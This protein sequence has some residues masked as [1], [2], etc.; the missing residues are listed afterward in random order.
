M[1]STKQMI[2]FYADVI[3]RLT[4]ASTVN[5][6]CCND[7][8][9]ESYSTT[10]DLSK[11]LLPE[12]DPLEKNTNFPSLKNRNKS[13]V[14]H[15]SLHL[16]S[17]FK[18]QKEG[19]FLIHFNLYDTE[20]PFSES[21]YEQPNNNERRAQEDN[22]E[23]KSYSM[24]LGLSFTQQLPTWLSNDTLEA[25]SLSKHQFYPLL[26][27]I[28]KL[29]YI[30]INHLRQTTKLLQ[31]PVTYLSSRIEFQNNLSK[32]IEDYSQVAMIMINPADFQI[33]NK[34]FGHDAGDRVITE[35]A[36]ILS[37]IIR[38]NDLLSRFGG[39][40]FVVALPLKSNDDIATIANKLYARLQQPEYLHGALLPQFKLGAAIIDTNKQTS[41]IAD[42][43]TELISKADQAL[44][45]AKIESQSNIVI[46]HPQQHQKYQQQQM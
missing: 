26:E 5:I 25:E 37:Q 10:D 12:F 16:T 43:V 39:A 15:S 45:A 13:L 41:T 30:L 2:D 20:S 3:A 42:Y 9:V 29:G 46:W 14:S 8:Q 40:L 31:D 4:G 34:K 32:L 36:Q 27:S 21:D 23:Q 33:I 35:I 18:S 19:S 17:I 22:V 7:N 44:H 11:Q 1:S 24:W 38:K 6:F 28:L